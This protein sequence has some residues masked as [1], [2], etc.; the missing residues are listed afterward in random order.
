VSSIVGISGKKQSGKT[1]CGNFLFGS[2]MLS[3][4]L[5]EYA[6]ISPE[7]QL[8]VP[9]DF[10]DETKAS[11]F[12]VD[13]MN[14]AMIDFMAENIWSEVKVY[15][16]ADNLK[17]IC[18]DILG[19]T[20]RQCY[21]TEEDKSSKTHINLADVVCDVTRNRKMTAREVMQHV[22]TD[23]FRRIYPQVWVDSTIRKIKK[24][25][26]KLAIIVDCRFENEVEGIQEVGG[27]V[28]RLTRNIFGD[29]DQ[30]PSETALDN[31]EGF[32]FVLDNQK[33]SLK[34]QNEA[35]YNKLVDWDFVD[36][37]AVATPL[38]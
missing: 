13:S 20:E 30:H 29:S 31:Y 34:E 21:G 17:K 6:H 22:G 2:A 32:D 28:I 36:Y 5:V 25:K 27:K 10:G 11:I 1:S 7:G 24:E 38:K 15:N 18:I 4:G 8:I 26:P 16:F 35:V 37:K 3:V 23:F 12:P 33:M 19:L 9:F 14:P